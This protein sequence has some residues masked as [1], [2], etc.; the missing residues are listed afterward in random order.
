[1]LAMGIVPPEPPKYS[2]I[3]N[4]VLHAYN[5]IARSRVYENGVPMALNTAHI[6][7][8]IE[9]ND[10]PCEL[11]IFMDCIFAIDN[12]YIDEAYKKL[13]RKSSK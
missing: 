10:L 13:K 4:A 12:L 9:L 5:T 11:Y 3:A 1:M 6:Q 8:Y 2:Y 7:S